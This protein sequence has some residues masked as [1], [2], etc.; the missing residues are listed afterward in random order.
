M[1][2]R[3]IF[4]LLMVGLVGIFV[5]AGSAQ[6]TRTP[7]GNKRMDVQK[8]RI[9]RGVNNGSLTRKEAAR[10]KNQRKEV[11]NNVK[12]AK[13]DGTLTVKERKG[14]R[15][16]LNKSSKSIYKAKHNKK[17]RKY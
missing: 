14:L 9:T 2:K 15:R 17:T 3:V 7:R 11:K 5:V 13:S 10:L 6:T 1:L 16:D 8:T 4:S 12:T